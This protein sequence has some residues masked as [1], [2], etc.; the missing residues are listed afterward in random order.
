M[1]K[2]LP[3]YYKNI[4]FINSQG[5]TFKGYLEPPFTGEDNP[6]FTVENTKDFGGIMYHP[7]NVISWK[8]V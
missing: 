6:W 3:E 8:Y 4:S 7:N 5:K 2:E 1:S